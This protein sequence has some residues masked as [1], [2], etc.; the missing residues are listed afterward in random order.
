MIRHTWE[1]ASWAHSRRIIVPAMLITILAV[2]S[3]CGT[4]EDNG[5]TVRPTPLIAETPG[6]AGVVLE[7]EA[8][9]FQFATRRFQLRQGQAATVELQ[10]GGS[11]QHS[12][13]AYLDDEY[14]QPLQGA[15]IP[16]VDAGKSATTALNPPEATKELFFRCEV[17]PAMTGEIEIGPAQPG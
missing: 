2:L 9:D 4:T 17:H 10:N 13:K 1:A 5:E 15:E 7:V 8:V 6:G 16:P 12:F 3:A 11:T 14:K